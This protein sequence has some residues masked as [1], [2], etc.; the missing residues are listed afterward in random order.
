MTSETLQPQLHSLMSGL[1]QH[2][3]EELLRFFS[4]AQ[5]A[6]GGIDGDSPIKE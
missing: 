4:G 6:Q 3:Q 2:S 1:G 5:G